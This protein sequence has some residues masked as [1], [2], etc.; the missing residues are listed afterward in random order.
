[1][2]T[3]LEALISKGLIWGILRTH[4]H[5]HT[6]VKIVSQRKLPML[7]AHVTSM[8]LKFQFCTLV[9]ALEDPFF[10]IYFEQLH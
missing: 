4:T 9:L 2:H 8:E 10:Y 7:N 6:S 5:T 1:M 3:N